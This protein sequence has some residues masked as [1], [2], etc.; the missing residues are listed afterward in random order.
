MVIKS[1]SVVMKVTRLR[2]V[3]L[4][5][6]VLPTSACTVC[7]DYEYFEFASNPETRVLET[8]TPALKGLSGVKP[9]PVSYVMNRPG[10][11]LKLRAEMG[12]GPTIVLSV[13][14]DKAMTLGKLPLEK[15]PMSVAALDGIGNCLGYGDRAGGVV[16]FKWLGNKNCATQ[17]TI[18]VAVIDATGAQIAVENLAFEVVKNGRWCVEDSL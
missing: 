14:S 12:Y 18:S 7:G 8:R 5:L 4:A 16:A 3:M 6:C 10:Y 9:F 1:M 17:W 2:R 11:Q 13:E 15:M